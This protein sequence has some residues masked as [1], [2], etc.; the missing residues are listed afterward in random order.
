MYLQSFYV[1]YLML[2]CIRTQN[3]LKYVIEQQNLLYFVY[4]ISLLTMTSHKVLYL[5]GRV[6]QQT[7]Q[8]QWQSSEN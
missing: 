5:V 7:P 1:G 2:L 3:E 4:S 8:S 6:Q